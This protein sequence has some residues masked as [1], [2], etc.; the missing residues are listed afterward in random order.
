MSLEARLTLTRADF[1][2]DADLEVPPGV[3]VLFGPSGAG[4]STVLRSIAGL[5]PTARGFVRAGGEVWHDDD[6]N[7]RLAAH[8]RA[9]GYVFQE[10]NLLPHRTVRGNLEF[11]HRRSSGS[12]PAWNDVVSFLALEPLLDRWPAT[13]S[14]GE[15][16]RV[17]LGRALL[18]R[19]RVLLLD[20]PVSALDEVAR[21]EVLA[22]LERLP[23]RFS[24]P[25]LFV[26]HT[27]DEAVRV[28]GRLI[29]LD[30]GRVRAQGPLSETLAR[31]DFARW[32]DDDAG[33]VVEGRVAAHD[34]GDHLTDLDGPWGTLTVHRQPH[35]VGTLVRVRVLARDV[36][37]ALAHE[38]DSTLLNQFPVEVRAVEPYRKGEVLVRLGAGDGP[39]LLARVTGRSASR[40]GIAPHAK[41]Y[42]RIKAVAVLD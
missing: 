26:T 24:L 5:E 41:L 36:S 20:E 28:G 33:V 3:T 15:R 37:L 8:R 14:G 39:D 6:R 29:W 18:R 27:L 22:M 10:A 25:V 4:K 12:G 11:G 1:R 38:A 13:L 30:A 17:A 40:L 34:D 32:R 42:A 31:T 9:V 21:R 19:P 23:A 16:Q 2:L 7:V 35:P